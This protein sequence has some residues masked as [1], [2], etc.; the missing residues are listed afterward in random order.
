MISAAAG[1]PNYCSSVA[2]NQFLTAIIRL[3]SADALLR[4]AC[5]VSKHAFSDQQY[6][7]VT[8]EIGRLAHAVESSVGARRT[9]P[10]LLG[11]LNEVLFEREGFQPASCEAPIFSYLPQVLNLKMGSV[12][13]VSMIYHVV[14][15]RLHIQ[16]QPVQL[17]NRF[18][19]RAQGGAGYLYVDPVCGRSL[20]HEEARMATAETRM[21]GCGVITREGWLW[22]L[23]RNLQALLARGDHRDDLAAVM[24][25]QN[26]LSLAG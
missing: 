9:P 4:A 26:L 14:A 6:S 17:L 19:I 1:S 7:D 20:S 12:E 8:T 16:T 2:Y 11:A 21:P 23:L 5:A 18:C 13:A 15:D 3:D 10:V 25:L 24:E 22:R